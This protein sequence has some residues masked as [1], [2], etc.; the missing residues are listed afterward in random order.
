M[1]SFLSNS[2]LLLGGGDV[3]ETLGGHKTPVLKVVLCT[4]FTDPRYG[5]REGALRRKYMLLKNIYTGICP[6]DARCPTD[7]RVL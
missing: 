7:E 3:I 6:T 1:L 4:C 5:V 2:Y